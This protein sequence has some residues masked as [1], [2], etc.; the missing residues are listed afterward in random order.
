VECGIVKQ[1]MKCT[2]LPTQEKIAIH[3]ILNENDKEVYFACAGESVKIVIKNSNFDD[4]R[5]GDVIC[6]G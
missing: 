6:G 4:I 2:L 5:R 3:Q 1:G